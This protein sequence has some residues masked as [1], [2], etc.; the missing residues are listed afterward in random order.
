MRRR[1]PSCASSPPSPPSPQPGNSK[2]ACSF[3]FSLLVLILLFSNPATRLAASLMAPA[4]P[5]STAGSP[6]A[7]AHRKRR[8]TAL[9]CEECRERKRKCDGIKPVCGACARRSA[10]CCVW[11]GD[12]SYVEGLK[13]RIRDLEEQVLADSTTRVDTASSCG[14][15]RVYAGSAAS[16]SQLPEPRPDPPYPL[17]PLHPFHPLHPLHPP[18]PLAES[19]PHTLR[20]HDPDGQATDRTSDSASLSAAPASSFRLDASASERP[21]HNFDSVSSDSGETSVDGMGVVGS[22]NGVAGPRARRQ[23]DYFGPSST[24]SLLARARNVL[25]RRCCGRG[26]PGS[27]S[28]TACRHVSSISQPPS[29][30]NGTAMFGFSVP[31]RAEADSLLESYWTWVHS[32]YPFLHQ[33]SFVER[34][35]AIWN[36][37]TDSDVLVETPQ[38][39]ATA[40]YNSLNDQSF[41]CLLNVVFAMGALF[42]PQI[43]EQDRGSVSRS[44]FDR[45]KKLL[46]LDLLAQGCTPLVQ[47]LLLMGQYLQST[48]MSSSCWNIVGMAIRV[49]QCIGLHHDPRG[50]KQGCCPK[51]KY[52]QLDIEMRRRT[53]TGC[54]L[55]DRVLSL[56]Y[57]RP[58][59]I[60]PTTTQKQLFLPSAID[61]QY[62]TCLLDAPGSQP[63]G[64]PSL[65]E[66][67]VQAIKLQDILGQVL[68]AFYYAAP[69]HRI[70]DTSVFD[71]G[72]N[73]MTSSVVGD[74]IRNSDFQMLL[75]VDSL[76]TTW[77]DSLV[78]HLKVQAY[79]NGGVPIGTGDS[80][81]ASMFHRQAVVLEVRYLHT[82]LTML[83]PMLSVL[84]DLTR[85]SDA[86]STDEDSLESNM[87]HGMLLKA[88]KLCLSV[89]Q[90]LVDLITS[91]APLGLCPAPW[92][93]VFYIHSCAMVFLLG[94][95]CLPKPTKIIEDATLFTGYDR[96]L[97]FLRSYESH[98]RS[99]KRCSKI[100]DFVKQE[101]FS[102]RS[103][104][105]PI[106]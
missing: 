6:D 7:D 90:D 74:G 105:W 31:P 13:A 91:K 73:Y 39:R 12:R 94:Y 57:G 17:H 51:Q 71:F 10:G 77:H 55:L 101:V 79:Q 32:L 34:Y 88:A 20:G 92:Y 84:C 78:P 16:P 22:L 93:N 85:R 64:V 58:L 30:R 104:R 46:D 70:E 14:T 103:S 86:T 66:C 26:P 29:A 102:S 3:S 8:R 24:V 38:R 83:R 75:D 89:A 59:M 35:L 45:A 47:M 80:V 65:M 21:E 41:Y 62:L 68:A 100:L 42:S 54:M 37:R 36:P 67:Y 9:A 5:K 98:S 69:D 19:A 33:L 106:S 15:S 95:L 53:W 96:C 52:D 87:R 97:A 18:P 27:E 11:N 23:S 60:H 63:D 40:Y 99:A 43:E 56:T 28:C 76:L 2:H 44:F 81:R 48:D 61:D 82:R 4:T 1:A 25:G 49:A 72:L 50:C